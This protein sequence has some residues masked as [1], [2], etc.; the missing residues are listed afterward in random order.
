MDCCTN[1]SKSA[2][3]TVEYSVDG[4]CE[5]PIAKKNQ[6]DNWGTV[7]MDVNLRGDNEGVSFLTEVTPPEVKHVEYLKRN[8]LDSTGANSF[9]QSSCADMQ[10][11]PI[12]LTYR[13]RGPILIPAKAIKDLNDGKI[14]HFQFETKLNSGRIIMKANSNTIANR[15]DEYERLEGIRRASLKRKISNVEGSEPGPSIRPSTNGVISPPIANSAHKVMIARN[16][17][18]TNTM[19]TSLNNNGISS[20]T[21]ALLEKRGFIYIS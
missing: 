6:M 4:L 9:A 18:D 2:V 12:M 20:S 8:G 13:A 7:T 10:T 5:I 1:G 11:F 21:R 19:V 3:M 16:V 14:P 15:A 17:D